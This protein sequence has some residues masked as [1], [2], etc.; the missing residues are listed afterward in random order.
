[1]RER[2]R[3]AA[4][5]SGARDGE[6][7]LV[8]GA[9]GFIG[10]QLVRELLA[11]GARVSCLVRRSEQAAE[12]ARRGVEPRVGDL[13]R[14][15][16]LDGVGGFDLVFHLAGVL[17]ARRAEEFERVNVEG[18]RNLYEALL[19]SARPPRRVVHVS[20]I[21]AGGP[22]AGTQPRRE[23]DPADP[24]SLY[25]RTKLAGEKVAHHYGHR[26]PIVILRPAVVYGPE[27]LNLLPIF[28][29][30]AR[31]WVLVPPEQPKIY[32]L[33]HVEDLARVMLRAARLEAMVGGTYHVATGEP[34]GW[35]GLIAAIAD[36]LG[37][38]PRQLHLG[39]LPYVLAA[40]L[41]A[42]RSRFGAHGP[43]D[44]LIPQKLPELFARYWHVDTTAL[45]G[46]MDLD[47]IPLA[48]GIRDTARWYAR[49]GWLAT[50]AAEHAEVVP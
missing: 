37:T 6:R 25:G 17:A 16:T 43:V 35:D 45:E 10:R 31:G 18:P 42:L 36:A 7:V 40:W 1:M 13:T 21:A 29:M 46:A 9:T 39:R 27:D 32:S 4:P 15:E 24:V 38:R 49:Q 30:V 11:G 44:L 22:S 12:L 26:L 19:A 5:D 33:V 3:N 23:D 28:Q 20:S 47:S 34:C 2:S 14:P 48:G 41:N 50:G 8:T